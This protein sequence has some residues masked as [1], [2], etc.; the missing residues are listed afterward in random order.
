MEVVE[1]QRK[2]GSPEHNLKQKPRAFA[3]EEHEGNP[4]CSDA[5]FSRGGLELGLPRQPSPIV[6][7]PCVTESPDHAFFGPS[8]R[9]RLRRMRTEE[10]PG[11]AQP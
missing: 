5:G 1:A 4:D 8:R 11:A 9:P 2:G 6:L 10:G 7:S 3:G